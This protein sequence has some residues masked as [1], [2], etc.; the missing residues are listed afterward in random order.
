M[1]GNYW[2][3]IGTVI[4]TYGAPTPEQWAE[5]SP[6]IADEKRIASFSI[7]HGNLFIART[8]FND[9]QWQK[10]LSLPLDGSIVKTREPLSYPNEM[11]GTVQGQVF[12]TKEQGQWWHEWLTSSGVELVEMNS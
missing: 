1:T 10:L 12:Y 11:Y 4:K 9:E 7:Q 8:D 5:V 6:L 3:R 2:K